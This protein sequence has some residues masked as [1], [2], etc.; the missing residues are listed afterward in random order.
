VADNAI[1][2]AL[3]AVSDGTPV[4]WS[5]LKS[6]VASDFDRDCLKWLQLLGQ[7][8]ELHRTTPADDGVESSAGES[9]ADDST[10][11]PAPELAELWGKYELREMVGEGSFG[12]VYR[13]WDPQLE[14]ELAIKIL[15]QRTTDGRLRA[16]LLAEGRALA[17]IRHPNVVRVLGIESNGDR[18]GLCMDFVRGQTLDDVIQVQG[19]MNAMEAVLVGRDVC[20][21]LAAVHRANFIH[22]DVKARN[23]VREQGGRFVLMDFGAGRD[24]TQERATGGDLIGTPLYMAPEVLAGGPASPCSDVYSVG[25]LLFYLVTGDFPVYCRTVEELRLAHRYGDRQYLTQI[26]PDLPATFVRVVER[27]LATSPD[28]RYPT[29]AALLDELRN[30]L[31]QEPFKR[32]SIAEMLVKVF[33]VVYA[34]V[35]ITCFAGALGI[36]STAMFNQALGLSSF[37]NDHVSDWV[38]WGAKSTLLPVLIITIVLVVASHVVMLVRLVTDGSRRTRLMDSVHVRIDAWI[39]R[40]GLND[41]TTAASAA[42]VITTASVAVALWHFYPLLRAC[43]E[44]ISTAS[45]GSLAQLSPAAEPNHS[46]FRETFTLLALSSAAVWWM[47]LRLASRHGQRVNR[48]ML[49]G[50]IG[51]TILAAAILSV[52]YRVLRHSAFEMAS[53]SGYDCYII[54]ERPADVLLFCPEAQTPRNRIVSRSD[55]GLQR[56]GERENIFTRFSSDRITQEQQ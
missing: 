40:F 50:G 2:Q 49:A 55:K 9:R 24:L 34:A 12:A 3:E 5:A 13:A 47:V 26:R 54:G 22:K 20:G 18:V 25:V 1:E 11:V 56:L 52:P 27:A 4:D 28:D 51:V 45:F 15:H 16:N 36:L 32:E 31:R 35:G 43:F 19:T 46:L 30:V 44:P 39:R 8:D 33:Y 53:W 23:V 42:L 7:L 29:A 38:I 14:S 41:V 6:D 37:A 17:K 10:M 21:A 48:S